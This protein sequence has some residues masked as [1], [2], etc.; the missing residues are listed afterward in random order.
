M[1]TLKE[2]SQETMYSFPTEEH[3]FDFMKHFPAIY[4]HMTTIDEFLDYHREQEEKERMEA[5]ANGWE[6]PE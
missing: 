3:I 4:G 6:G 1:K 2:I 5:Y